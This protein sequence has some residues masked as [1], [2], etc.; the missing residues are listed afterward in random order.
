MG[1]FTFCG[2][3]SLPHCVKLFLLTSL[4][5]SSIVKTDR[6]HGLHEKKGTQKE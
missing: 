3:T 6:P 4:K 1:V 2:F 5:K